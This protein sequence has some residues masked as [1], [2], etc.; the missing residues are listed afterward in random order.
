MNMVARVQGLLAPSNGLRGRELRAKPEIEKWVSGWGPCGDAE[1]QES[2]SSSCRDGSD[3][4]GLGCE[5]CE[6]LR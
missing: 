1:G 4:K 6:V 2:R 5:V 3:R